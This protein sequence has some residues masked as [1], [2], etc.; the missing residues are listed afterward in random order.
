MA[1]GLGGRQGLLVL[2]NYYPDKRMRDGLVHVAARRPRFHLPT[3][4]FTPT[5]LIKAVVASRP[6][7]N[8]TKISKGGW[9]IN[10][11]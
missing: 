10:H 8:Q 11:S 6:G 2:V 7:P 9:S 5:H 1:L 4:W 3:F